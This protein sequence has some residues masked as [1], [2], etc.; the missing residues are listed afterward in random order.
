MPVSKRI[1][2]RTRAMTDFQR[3]WP[4]RKIAEIAILAILGF[5]SR[6]IARKLDDGT[7]HESIR[8][9][10]ATWNVYDIAPGGT[11]KRIVVRMHRKAVIEAAKLAEAEGL[12]LEVWAGRI[13]EFAARDGMYH[14][15][16]DG[17]REAYEG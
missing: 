4:A 14:S 1:R 2:R 8:H 13:L 15:I 11:K 9:Q 6:Q 5:S 17:E 10:L 7:M 16:V 3:Q 12:T